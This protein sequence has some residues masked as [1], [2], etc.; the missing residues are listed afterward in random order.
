MAIAIITPGRQWDLEQKATR[1]L[2]ADRKVRGIKSVDALNEEY[3]WLTEEQ[4]NHRLEREVF[5]STGLPDPHIVSGM[6][7]RVYNPLF[8]KRPQRQLSEV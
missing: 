7:Q 3:S 6:F 8:G 2:K 1:M 5:T 4:L